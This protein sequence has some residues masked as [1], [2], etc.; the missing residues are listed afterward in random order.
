MQKPQ[1]Y[2]ETQAF[3]GD[4]EEIKPGGYVCV[5]KKAKTTTTLGGKEQ[6]NIL[7]D[8]A[9]GEHKGFYQRR[10]DEDSSSSSE[11]KWRGVYRQL[12]EGKSLAFFKGMITSMEASNRGYKWNWDEKTLEGKMFGGLFGREQYKNSN[13]EFKWTTKCVAVRSVETIRKGV[14]AP[15]DKY[16]AESL[17]GLKA[18]AEKAGVSVSE[19]SGFSVIPPDDGLPF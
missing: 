11:P 19:G 2:D 3:T 13:G 8:I 1:G 10:F 14:E 18:S 9:E 5:I 17:E 15:K 4:F 6:F 7:F 16:H 12:T